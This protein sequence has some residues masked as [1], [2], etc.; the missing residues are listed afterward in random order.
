MGNILLYGFLSEKFCLLFKESESHSVKS[1]S[2]QPH[3]LYSPWNSL[4][5]NTEVDS[6]PLKF[7]AIIHVISFMFAI[8]V[9]FI[10]IAPLKVPRLLF[11]CGFIRYFVSFHCVPFIDY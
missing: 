3:G 2:L 7:I 8:C 11:S 10:F 6:L 4:G 1:D 9:S 5:Q